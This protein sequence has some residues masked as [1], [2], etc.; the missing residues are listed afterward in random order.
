[1]R[2]GEAE[3]ADA[4][5][6]GDPGALAAVLWHGADLAAAEARGDVEIAGSRRAARAF[7]RLFPMP[8]AA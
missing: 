6:A 5:I 4:T 2:R 3:N 1:M 8:A 7:L